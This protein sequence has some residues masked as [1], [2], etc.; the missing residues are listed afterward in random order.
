[1]LAFVEILAIENVWPMPKC[2]FCF[3]SFVFCFAVDQWYFIDQSSAVS[4][5]KKK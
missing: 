5:A 2:T 1:M 3:Q 4:N